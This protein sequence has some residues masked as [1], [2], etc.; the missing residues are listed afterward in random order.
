MIGAFSVSKNYHKGPVVAP[1]DL[2]FAPRRTL[3]SCTCIRLYHLALLSSTAGVLLPLESQTPAPLPST[4][5]VG[6]SVVLLLGLLI[7]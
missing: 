4:A 5:L 3:S 1:R 6:Q 2:L 7:I